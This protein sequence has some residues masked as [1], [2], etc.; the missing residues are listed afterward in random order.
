MIIISRLGGALNRNGK[1][2]PGTQTLLRGLR[3][4]EDIVLGSILFNDELSDFFAI[5]SLAGHAQG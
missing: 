2:P 1:E 3:R 4:F 5:N